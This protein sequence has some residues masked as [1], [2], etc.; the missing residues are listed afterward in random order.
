MKKW[1]IFLILLFLLVIPP[2]AIGSAAGTEL[3]TA[4]SVRITVVENGMEYEW[5]YD[6]PSHYEY[7]HGEHVIKGAKAKEKVEKIVRELMLHEK[8]DVKDFVSRLQTST[9]PDIERLDIRYMNGDGKLFTW[10]WEEE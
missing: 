2:A 9:Y 8:E 6:S 1:S 4:F 5:E 3:M 7:E 10:V